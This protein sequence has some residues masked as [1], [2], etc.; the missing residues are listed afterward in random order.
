MVN[1]CIKVNLEDYKDEIIS[2]VRARFSPEWVYSVDELAYWA[3]T[4]GYVKE[5]T[6]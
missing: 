1:R 4:H 2:Y 3:R 5:E 6:K